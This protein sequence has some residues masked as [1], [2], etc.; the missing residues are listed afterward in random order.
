LEFFGAPQEFRDQVLESRQRS[1]FE[2][3]EENRTALDVFLRVSTQWRVGEGV[4]RG[5][6][7]QALR[8]VIGMYAP[9]DERAVFE[10]VQAMEGAALDVLNKRHGA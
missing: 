1:D 5:L 10:R 6:D 4:V 7:Y 9:D 3:F 8:W 2:V